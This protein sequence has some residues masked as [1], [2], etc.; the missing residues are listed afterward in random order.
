M[1]NSHI[2]RCKL[3]QKNY[4][5]KPLIAEFIGTFALVFA[6]TGAIIVDKLTGVIGHIGISAT[7]GLVI[8]CM[9]YAVGHISGAHFNP[10]VTIA[11][12]AIKRFPPLQAIFY[13]LSQLSG[14]LLASIILRITFGNVAKLGATLPIGGLLPSFVLEIVLTFFLVFV[15]IA[16]A[17]D[18]CAPCM[19]CGLTIGMT[20]A[21]CALFGGPISG[22]S[23]NPAR[24]FGPAVICGD[25]SYLWLYIIA[26]IIGGLAGAKAYNLVRGEKLQN[27]VSN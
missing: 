15:I 17:T 6:G 3:F 16:V 12:V 4:F 25:L 11:F 23:M 21:F 24:S 20:V 10:A 7:F 19:M 18:E 13:I 1:I 22:A 27:E 2:Q 9:I 14:S 5:Y 26:P 8:M